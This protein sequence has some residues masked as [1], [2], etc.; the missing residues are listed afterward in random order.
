MTMMWCNKLFCKY[1]KSVNIEWWS[2]E[3]MVNKS[4]HCSKLTEMAAHK[5]R[6]MSDKSSYTH[7]Y[8][9]KNRFGSNKLFWECIKVLRVNI[10][11][12]W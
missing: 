7:N 6:I 3:P 10:S 11:P 9:R 5:A 1:I 12:N 4:K 8:G 2:Q